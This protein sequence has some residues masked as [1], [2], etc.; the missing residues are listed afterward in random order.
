MRGA[1]LRGTRSGDVDRGILGHLSRAEGARLW[2]R[3]SAG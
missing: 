2:R 3:W 1:A